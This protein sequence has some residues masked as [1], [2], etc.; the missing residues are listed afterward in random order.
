MQ[1]AGKKV[2]HLGFAIMGL[3]EG[4]VQKSVPETELCK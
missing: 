4:C 1:M 3:R 2:S